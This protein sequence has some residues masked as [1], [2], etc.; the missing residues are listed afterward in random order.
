MDMTK[1]TTIIILFSA[2]FSD[3]ISQQKN[4]KVQIIVGRNQLINSASNRFPTVEPHLAVNPMVVAAIVFDSAAVSESRTHIV[5][6]A[7]KDNGRNWK[8]TNLSMTVGFDPWVAIKND[9]EVAL[10]ALVGFGSSHHN[11]LVYYAS[12]D[13][14][15]TWG[16]DM[17]KFGGGHDHPTLIVNPKEND[18]LYI[19]SSFV[20]RDSAKQMISYAWLNFTDNWDSFP[21]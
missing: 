18:R 11:G 10:V 16:N 3:C 21:T 6:Y 4:S 9:N 19:L 2:L 17:I 14:G 15:F 7:T 12:H 13:G 5:V 8:Q 1:F 20:K